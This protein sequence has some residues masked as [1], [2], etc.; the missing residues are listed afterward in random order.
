M[1]IRLTVTF[2]VYHFAVVLVCD[3]RNNIVKYNGLKSR[4]ALQCQT[5]CVN[6]AI[7]LSVGVRPLV[8]LT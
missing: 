3:V 6:Y 8:S 5:V 4:T 7:S 2:G 1:V